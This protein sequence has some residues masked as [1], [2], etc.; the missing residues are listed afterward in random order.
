MQRYLTLGLWILTALLSCAS[1]QADAQGRGLRVLAIDYME[2]ALNATEILG[3]FDAEMTVADQREL[4]SYLLGGAIRDFDIVL[5]D[6]QALDRFL[7]VLEPDVFVPVCETNPSLCPPEPEID[8]CA[9]HPWVPFCGN[10]CPNP[11]MC[12]P[13]IVWDIPILIDPWDP[14]RWTLDDLIR[15]VETEP[16]LF[17]PRNEVGFLPR[18]AIFDLARP[19]LTMELEEAFLA[20]TPACNYVVHFEEFNERGFIPIEVEGYEEIP[21][22]VGA[23][24]IAGGNVELATEFTAQLVHDPNVQRAFFDSIMLLPA[25]LEVLGEILPRR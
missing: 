11:P 10:W 13:V 9:L 5:I 6:N 25:N 19:R 3:Q 7:P 14:M 8:F 2:K 23:Y 1:A 20:I 4:E 15:I 24:V 18:S 22:N 12:N 21:F 16:I 17:D